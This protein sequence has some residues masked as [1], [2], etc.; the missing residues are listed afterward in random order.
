[1]KLEKGWRL[2]KV[3]EKRQD[4]DEIW[5]VNTKN[6]MKSAIYNTVHPVVSANQC[7]T[8]RRIE[9][10]IKAPIDLS[11]PTPVSVSVSDVLPKVFPAKTRKVVQISAIENEVFSLCDDGT[12]WSIAS[13]EDRWIKLPNIP[14]PT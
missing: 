14:Q 5:M 11:I 10:K 3:G 12:V 9:V 4:G 8:R 13:G 7:A 2:L 6:W 1:M